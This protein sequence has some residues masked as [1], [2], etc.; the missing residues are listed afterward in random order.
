LKAKTLLV[1]LKKRRYGFMVK[2]SGLVAVSSWAQTSVPSF[3]NWCSNTYT[4]NLQRH[5]KKMHA[6][7]MALKSFCFHSLHPP[8]TASHAVGIQLS[9][10]GSA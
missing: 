5:Y 7:L 2:S 1:G 6:N 3:I 8:I 9:L 10:V 4:I